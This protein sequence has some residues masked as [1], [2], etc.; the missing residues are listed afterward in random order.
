MKRLSEKELDQKIEKFLSRKNEEVFHSQR[1]EL[2]VDINRKS[3][4]AIVKFA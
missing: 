4:F 3:N 2:V 1:K